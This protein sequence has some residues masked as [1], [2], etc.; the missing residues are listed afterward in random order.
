[1]QITQLN[2]NF[3]NK[4]TPPTWT[5]SYCQTARDNTKHGSYYQNS[6][7]LL[8]NIDSQQPVPVTA[9]HH[10]RWACETT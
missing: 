1:V 7:T 10:S 9:R 3:H 5:E 8:K 4:K 6:T 2:K